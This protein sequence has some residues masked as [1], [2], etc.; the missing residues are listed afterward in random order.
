MNI[1]FAIST[2]DISSNLPLYNRIVDYLE[3]YGHKMLSSYGMQSIRG[4][5]L[6][7]NHSIDLEKEKSLMYSADLVI[8]ESSTGSFNL[9]ALFGHATS[10]KKHVLVLHK[11]E[12]KTIAIEDTVKSY[13]SSLARSMEYTPETLEIVLKRYFK[14]FTPDAPVKFNFIANKDIVAFIEEGAEREG[15]SKSEY[16]RDLITEEFLK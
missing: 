11:K 2:T 1:Y 8:I 7:E 4:E 13:H 15:K 10:Y 3:K 6:K 14:E 12:H 16:L 9:G 5:N